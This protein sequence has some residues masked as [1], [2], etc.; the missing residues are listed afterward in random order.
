ML[1]LRRRGVLRRSDLKETN[2]RLI[3]NILR[4]DRDISR[5]DIVKM[6]GLSAS[7]VTFIVKR[8]ISEGLISADRSGVQPHVGR[9]PISLKLRPESMYAIGADISTEVMRVRAA[10]ISGRT[11]V[12]RRIAWHARPAVA[13]PRLRTAIS[14]VMT[15]FSDRRLVGIGVGI[16]GTIARDTGHVIA[17]EELGWFD[18]DAG[19]ILGEG[20]AVKPIVEND[21]KLAAFAEHWFHSEEAPLNF[22]FVAGARGLGTGIFVDGHL[23]QGASGEGSEFGHIV[24]YPD[25]RKCL[26]GGRGCWEE[27]ASARALERL[28]AERQHSAVAAGASEIIR[29]A[30]NGDRQALDALQETASHVGLGFVNIRQAFDPEEIIV[31][32]YLAEAWDLIEDIVWKVLRERIAP[33]YLDRLRIVPSTHTED[34]TLLGAMGMALSAW[35][36]ANDR[37]LQRRR[38]TASAK[39]A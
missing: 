25:G 7:S 29:R 14:G 30:R 36:G 20:L 38:R 13:L 4:Q 34:S 26:C 35:F 37:A 3:L 21:A 27:Y 33:R 16:P 5:S 1:T 9:P 32:N 39:H 10:D 22:V 8:L 12:D 2:E 11:L 24:L 28:Y 31:G 17:A 6:T 23:L 18:V 19:R 15:R